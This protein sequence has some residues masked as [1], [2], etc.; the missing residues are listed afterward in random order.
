MV[1]VFSESDNE[2][3]YE[4]DK[5]IYGRYEMPPPVSGVTGLGLS[6]KACESV[7][8]L[9]DDVSVNGDGGCEL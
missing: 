1:L 5:E 8:R 9:L 6:S 7:D 3:L 4:F 2:E